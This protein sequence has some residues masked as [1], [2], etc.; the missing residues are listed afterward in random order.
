LQG[1]FVTPTANVAAGPG[2][3][4][5]WHHIAIRLPL[6]F[7]Q[8]ADGSLDRQTYA[9]NLD[10][11]EQAIKVGQSVRLSYFGKAA[12]EKV[13]PFRYPQGAE[14]C[15]IRS[16]LDPR[17]GEAVRVKEVGYMVKSVPE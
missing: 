10:R 3:D 15:F 9:E 2:A 17:Q 6:K 7:R 12:D 1:I 5:S 11:L 13:V 8:K 14:F 4:S 16:Y